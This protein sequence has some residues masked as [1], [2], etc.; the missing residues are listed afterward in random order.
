MLAGAAGDGWDSVESCNNCNPRSR[1]GT[2]AAGEFS[3]AVAGDI[4]EVLIRGHAIQRRKEL[5]GLGKQLVVQIL[6]DLKE[7]VV[8]AERVVTHGAVEIGK[9]GLLARESFENA[10]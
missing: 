4:Y 9:I 2:N 10:E 6:L 8:D 5:P 1:R 7:D 3:G